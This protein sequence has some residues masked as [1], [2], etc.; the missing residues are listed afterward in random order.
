MR[1]IGRNDKCPCKSGKKYKKCHG[2]NSSIRDTHSSIT[3]EEIQ[4]L[5]EQQEGRRIQK[6]KQQGKGKGIIAT[7]FQG[8]IAL[9]LGNRVY[10]FPKAQTFHDVLFNY[11]IS[12]F[13]QNWFKQQLSKESNPPLFCLLV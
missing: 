8:G 11:P 2:M 5:F 3:K 6:E 1:K 13:G 9:A 7:K 10:N 4:I 12:L